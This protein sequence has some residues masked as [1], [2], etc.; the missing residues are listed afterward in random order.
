MGMINCSECSKDISDKATSCPQCGAPVNS[1]DGSL[2]GKN[3]LIYGLIL[4]PGSLFSIWQ[5][6]K[7][8]FGSVFLALGI[9]M[10]VVGIIIQ[11][12]KK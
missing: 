7:S 8:V 4:I 11:S 1:N 12:L 6:P 3:I 2:A 5:F 10:I 9:I